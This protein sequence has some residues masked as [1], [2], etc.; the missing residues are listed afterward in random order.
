M[1]NL[2]INTKTKA[3]PTLP[4]KVERTKE[5]T[6]AIKREFLLSFND[7]H[8]GS[9]KGVK[10][11][12]LYNHI[13]QG[14]GD[15]LLVNNKIAN[16]II[17]TLDVKRPGLA[18]ELIGNSIELKVPKI[19]KKI[20]YQ[21]VN[22]FKDISE[23][24]GNSEAF[25][26]VYYDTT[27]KEY[28]CHVPEQ[29]VSPSSVRYDATKNLNVVDRKRYISVFE[30]HSHNTMAAF[31][32]GID[33]KDE[34][35]T[36]FYGVF[37]RIKDQE[38]DEKYRFMVMGK[39]IDLTKEHIFDFSKTTPTFSKEELLEYLTRNEKD[40]YDISFI[41]KDLLGVTSDYPAEWKEK[42]SVYRAPPTVHRGY[43]GASGKDPNDTD[44]SSWDE[45]GWENWGEAGRGW[46]NW[47]HN[48]GKNSGKQ[49]GGEEEE[50]NEMR[51]DAHSEDYM[52]K[53][54]SDTPPMQDVVDIEEMFDIT[55]YEED[56]H[57]LILDNFACSLEKKHVTMFLEKLVDYGHDY[58]IQQFKR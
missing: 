6:E 53:Y 40:K 32:S 4:V 21:I 45:E 22:F 34:Q 50:S 42:V 24:V 54:T 17:K 35:E 15:F 26:Q 14:N 48:K 18:E 57:D 1:T 37:G 49:V 58:E 27:N 2:A 12:K 38:I 56:C 7:Y 33:N 46:D 3:A 23:K 51:S 47:S 36:K 5:E 31:W 28:I 9:I 30:V 55:T 39:Q 43:A 29:E 44:L 11:D 19:P 8:V 20:Y 10:F 13:I 16:F 25:V 41:A 52:S